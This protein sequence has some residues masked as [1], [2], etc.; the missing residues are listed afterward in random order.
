[1]LQKQA[2]NLWICDAEQ[3]LGLGVRMPLRMTVLR[4]PDETLT[5]ISPIRISD[6]LAAELATLGEVS[7]LIAPNALHHLHLPAAH[8]RYPRARVLVAPGVAAKQPSVRAEPL[9]PEAVPA[10]RDVLAAR[11]IEGV[12]KISEVVLYHAPSR[13]LI[14]TDFVFNIEQPP[15]FATALVLAC[16]GTNGKLAQSR[17]WNWL[18]KDAAAAHASSLALFEWDFERVIV[19]H[20]NVIAKDAKTRLRAAL[21]RTLSRAI[22]QLIT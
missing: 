14:V 18:K 12:P 10:L 20:G 19:A 2:E 22:P 7:A 1:M 3:K 4:L 13:A 17:A 8:A 5:L 6:A 9:V 15:N 11:L 16:T 21:T